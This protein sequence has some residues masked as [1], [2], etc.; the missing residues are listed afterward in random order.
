LVVV[1]LEGVAVAAA[2]G[3]ALAAVLTLVDTVAAVVP[4]AELVLAAAVAW[5]PIPWMAMPAERPPKASTLA[6]TDASLRRRR[7]RL[8]SAIDCFRAGKLPLAAP[9]LSLGES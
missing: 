4:L 6:V 9:A 5:L 1:V 7:R 3:A 8:A 2:A